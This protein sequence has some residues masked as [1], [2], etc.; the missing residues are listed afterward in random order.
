MSFL[1]FFKFLFKKLFRSRE[2]NEELDEEIRFHLGMSIDQKM[3]Q[4]MAREEA[5]RE[6]RREFGSD[7]WVR[8]ACRM[9]WGTRFVDDTMQDVRMAMRRLWKRPAYSVPVIFILAIA[10]GFCGTFSDIL[11]QRVLHPLAYPN[12]DEIIEISVS[13]PVEAFSEAFVPPS[14]WMCESVME[15]K[16]TF[17]SIGFFS[18]RGA[19][20]KQ[21]NNSRFTYILTMSPGAW[22]VMGIGPQYGRAFSK[23][24]IE[25]GDSNVVVVTYPFAVSHYG[26]P[27]HALGEQL[28]IDDKDFVIIGVMAEGVDLPRACEIAIPSNDTGLSDMEKYMELRFVICRLLPGV[29]MAQLNAKLPVAMDWVKER[30]ANSKGLIERFHVHFKTRPYLNAFRDSYAKL[31]FSDLLFTL[32]GL[33][34]FLYAIACLNWLTVFQ[35]N[36]IR[37]HRVTGICFGLGAPRFRLVCGI[38]MENLIMLIAASMLGVFISVRLHHFANQLELFE[39]SP[40][41]NS[42]EGIL[43]ILALMISGWVLSFPFILHHVGQKQTQ[44]YLHERNSTTSLRSRSLY[45]LSLIESGLEIVVIL[46]AVFLSLNMYRILTTDFG[47]EYKNRAVAEIKIPPWEEGMSEAGKVDLLKRIKAKLG[48]VPELRSNTICATLPQSALRLSWI[49]GSFNPN[50][51]PQK[52]HT[53]ERGNTESLFYRSNLVDPDFVEVMGVHLLQG[54]WFEESDAFT[55][56]LETVVDERFVEDWFGSENPIGFEFVEGGKK[57]KHYR[58]I[59]VV[60]TLDYDSVQLNLDLNAYQCYQLYDESYTDFS[61]PQDYAVV[62]KADPSNAQSLLKLRKAIREVDSDLAGEVRFYRDDIRSKYGTML[63]MSKVAAGLSVVTVLI[64]GYGFFSFLYYRT[65][66]MQKEFAIR[67]AMGAREGRLLLHYMLRQS[68]SVG[69]GAAIGIVV[70]YFLMG[71]FGQHLTDVSRSDWQPYLYVALGMTGFVALS[72]LLPWFRMRKLELRELLVTE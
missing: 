17:A 59:G 52:G 63:L 14:V 29:T 36:L 68:V 26:K 39:I 12:A 71:Q 21:G 9:G 5:E 58:I 42:R 46:A 43:V 16:D 33:A 57:G 67:L 64:A 48:R 50:S 44:R 23:N 65:Q 6:A 69:I 53:Q 54:R 72:S 22:D 40:L 60:N 3:A 37:N 38:G 24:D 35:T 45:A 41:L 31:S 32:V 49:S 4:G 11:F 51:F 30:H 27:Q 61:L 34:L 62:C 15:L 66:L 47:F 7:L 13:H 8:E 55:P 1:H 56:E 2:S 28:R 70:V 20:L 19:F 18:P 25:A 10:L